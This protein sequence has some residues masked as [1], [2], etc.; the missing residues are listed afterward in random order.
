[1]SFS[2]NMSGH[3]GNGMSANGDEEIAAVKAVQD[4]ALKAAIEN[5]VELTIT[6]VSPNW[7][8]EKNS[9]YLVREAGK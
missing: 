1:M 4:A 2:I 7:L 5:N 9:T 6:S 3:A 8:T